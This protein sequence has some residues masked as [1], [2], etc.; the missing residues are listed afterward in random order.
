MDKSTNT[1][2]KSTTVTIDAVLAE[3]LADQKKRLKPTTVRKYN[4]I[5]ELLRAY[6]DSYGGQYLDEQQSAVFDRLYDAQGDAHREFCQIFGPDR[7]PPG[8]G[9]FLNYFMI[10]K[11]ACGKE[12]M[13][14]AGTV[15]RKLGRWLQER[16]YLE[17]QAAESMT[18]HGAAAAKT[19][20][21]LEDLARMLADYVEAHPVDCGEVLEDH[22]TI[23]AVEP[24]LLRLSPF[25]E[26]DEM[27]VPVSRK[28]SNACREGLTIS[29]AIGVTTKGWRL[30]EVW[31]VYP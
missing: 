30:V 31:N 14:A 18:Q 23:E 12:L 13:K 11:V 22:F 16:G 10:R 21:A 28:I 7:I 25:S 4:T 29:G 2:A 6:L 15:I 20:P 27:T 3:F 5:V 19:L 26:F 9:E 8:T 17:P 1:S 24:G